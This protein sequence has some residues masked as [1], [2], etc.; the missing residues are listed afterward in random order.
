MTAKVIRASGRL[1]SFRPEVWRY[2]MLP[3]GSRCK[4]IRE[5]MF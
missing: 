1:P 3:I 4:I 2:Y 5:I